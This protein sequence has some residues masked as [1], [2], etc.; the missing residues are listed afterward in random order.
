MYNNMSYTK[1]DV[2]MAPADAMDE[3]GELFTF[4]HDNEANGICLLR[5][6]GHKT[7][8]MDYHVHKE[9]GNNKLVI[10]GEIDGFVVVGIDMACFSYVNELDVYFPESLTYFKIGN[11]KR[12]VIREHFD[13][14]VGTNKIDTDIMQYCVGLK[15]VAL[16]KSVNE[17]GFEPFLY[18]HML[19][20]I[21]IDAENGVYS[22]IDG[23]LYDKSNT[24]LL[25]CPMGKKGEVVIPRGVIEI[26]DSAFYQCKQI[27]KVFVP[28]SVT[29]IGNAA[30]EGC[31]SLTE[32]TLP[33]SITGIGWCVFEDCRSLKEYV[34][35]ESIDQIGHRV[36]SGCVSL[37]SVI[38][39]PNLKAIG[40]S[41]FSDCASLVRVALPDCVE[42]IE[43]F[44][45]SGC[46]SLSD[47]N[48]P[49]SIVEVGCGVFAG[50]NALPRGVKIRYGKIRRKMYEKY[51]VS[52]K[53]KADVLSFR[54]MSE[55][56]YYHGAHSVFT[57]ISELESE[58]PSEKALKTA[59]RLAAER[60]ITSV[61][62]LISELKSELEHKGAYAKTIINGRPYLEIMDHYFREAA[63]SAGYIYRQNG[64]IYR[65]AKNIYYELT[66]SMKGKR[67]VKLIDVTYVYDLCQPFCVIVTE[68]NDEV[69]WRAYCHYQSYW[70]H[71]ELPVFRFAKKQY[72]E[73]LAQ[74]RGIVEEEF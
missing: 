11:I 13:I 7:D 46:T 2:N 33:D 65:Y 52:T 28:I 31:H 30:F 14:P 53:G 19:E 54:K 43:D 24:K 17:M 9:V 37:Q 8:L 61:S 55:Q 18:C 36:F 38:L 34:F 57:L 50:C 29:M 40:S 73:A 47:I 20:R 48:L 44:A 64:F 69:I 10:P 22:D 70:F 27:T 1:F 56:A 15:S 58:S 42:K 74:L 21:F 32:V 41:M 45:F 4:E 49:K 26:G 68:K 25:R 35:P 63:F 16:P 67:D 5:Y 62:E 72:Q 66:T 71:G 23:M 39:P 3:P 59:S 6:T 51:S 12:P 60:G